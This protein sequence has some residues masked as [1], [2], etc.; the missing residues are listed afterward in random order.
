[1]DSKLP[2]ASFFDSK[3]EMNYKGQKSNLFFEDFSK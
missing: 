2:S 1:M 3:W